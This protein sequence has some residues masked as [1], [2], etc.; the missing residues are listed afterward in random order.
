MKQ[1]ILFSIALFALMTISFVVQAGTP[2]A[3]GDGTGTSWNS[4]TSGTYYSGSTIALDGVTVTLGSTDDSSVTWTWHSGNAG[5]I[6]SQMPNTNGTSSTLITTF[7]ET[8]P[9]GTLPTRGCFL[10]I[11]ATADGILSVGCKPSTNS[12][13]KLVFVTMDADNPT[14]IASASVNGSIWDSSYNYELEAD[15]TYYLFQLAYSGQLSGYRFTLKSVSYERADNK[16]VKVF[17]IGDSTMANKSSATERGWGMIFPTFVDEGKVTICNYAADGRS[18]LSF[19]TEGR[20]QTVINQ[21]GDGDYVLI[22]FGHNDEKTDASLH[23]DPQTTYK[24][25]LTRFITESRAKGA[26]PVLLTPIVRRCFGSDGN[27]YDEH[28]EYAEAMRELA[29]ELSVPL[30]DMN[31]LSA[32]YENIAGIVGSRSLHEYF[33]GTEIDNTHLCQLGAY[34]TARSV[35]EQIAADERIAI[36]INSSPEALTGAY[37]STLD[38]AQHQFRSAYPSE[39]VPTTLAEIDAAVRHLRHEARQEIVN[40]KLLNG[41]SV[42]ATFALVNPDFAEGNC[43]YNTVQATRPMGWQLDKNTSGTEN[44]EVKTADGVT[45]FIVWAPTMNYIDMSQSVS[46]LPDGTYEVSALVKAS[47]GSDTGRTYLYARSGS[48]ETTANAE[49]NDTWTTIAVRCQVTDGQL[50][51]GL[52]SEGGWYAR[53]ADVHLT[54]INESS[55]P[56]QTPINIVTEATDGAFTIATPDGAAP[57]IYDAES[58]HTVVGIVAN[59]VA[60]DIAAITG[61]TPN[62]LGGFPAETPSEAIIAGTIGQS[63][64]IDALIASGKLDV[65]DI[66]GKWEVYKLQVIDNPQAGIDRALVIVGSNPRGTA[67]GLFELSR[68]MGVSPW[69]WWA[70]VTPEPRATLYAT[71]GTVTATEPS[72]RFRGFFIND[73]DWGMQPWAAKHMDT[74][75]QDIGPR[76][77]ERVFELLLRMR[78]NYMW[79]AMHECT[80]AFWYYEENPVLA[81]QY[82][83]VLGSSHAEPMLRNNVFEWFNEGGGWD[84]YNFATNAEGVT[85]YWRKRVIQSKDQEAV[86]TVGMRGIHDSGIAGYGGDATRTADGLTQIIATQRQLISEHIGDPTTVPQMFVPYKEVLSAYNT[87]RIDLPEDITL[88]WVDDNHGYIRQFPDANEQQRSGSHGIYYHLS[89]WGSP[90]DYLW[91]SSTSPSLISYELSRGYEQGIQRLWLINVGDI[92]PAEEEL[93]FCMDLAWDIDKWN[94]TEAAGYSRDWAARTFGEDVADELAAIKLEYYR[95]AAAGKPEHVCHTTYSRREMDERI[96]AYKA[97]ADRVATLKGS[98]PARLQDAYFQMVEYPVRGAYLMNVK[99]FRAAESFEYANAGMKTEALSAAAEARAAY[100]EI[101]TLTTTYNTGIASGKW[102]GMMSSKPRSQSAFNMPGVASEDDVATALSGLPAENEVVIPATAYATASPVLKAVDGLGMQTQALTTWPM[103]LTAYSSG[104]L[105]SAPSAEYDVPVGAGVNII[106]VHCLPTFPLNSSY[107]LRYAVSIDG[108]SATVQSIKTTAQTSAWDTNVLRGW[109]G[110]SHSYVSDAEKTVRVKIYF[111]DPGLVLSDIYCEQPSDSFTDQV[112]TNAD[113]EYSAE[114]VLNSGGSTVRGVPYGW[115]TNTTFPGTSYGINNDGSNRHGDNLCWFYNSGGT[116]PDFFQLSQTVS[117]LDAGTYRVQCRLWAQSGNLGTVRLFANQNVQ[118]YGKQTDYV[119]NLTDGEVNTFAGYSGTST[120]SLKD[121]QVVVTIAEGEDLTLGIRTSNQK[122]DGTRATSSSDN[123]GWFKCD[124]FRIE[125]YTAVA[126]IVNPGFGQETTGWTIDY[127]GTANVKISSGA[128]PDGSNAPLIA[129]DQNHLQIWGISATGSVSQTVVNLPNGRYEVGVTFCKSGTLTGTLFANDASVTLADNSIYKVETDVTDG[130]LS[131]GVT[132]SSTSGATL[133][134]DAFTLR[135]LAENVTI[136]E[137]ATSLSGFPA[138]AVNATLVRTLTA[139]VWQGFSLPFALTAEQI[140]ASPLADTEVV[141]LNTALSASPAENDGNTL[142]FSVAT[143]IEAGKPYFVRPAA[144][145]VNPTFEDVTITDTE[146]ESVTAGSYSFVA[147]LYNKDLPTDG[148]V[149][150]LSTAT[151]QFKRLTSGGINGLR[152]YLL[153][154]ANAEVKLYFGDATPTG[155]TQFP[156]LT[157]EGLGE[158]P[159]FDLSG[160]RVSTSTLSKG[161]YIQNGKKTIIK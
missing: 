135:R 11:V 74:D 129:A 101:Q 27:I 62:V 20:W 75:I 61:Q 93:E 148:T 151:G 29:T 71:A 157:G 117:G 2:T 131:L 68:M 146:G 127:S 37:T 97:I 70:D 94:P 36:A 15:H 102:D 149:A 110:G 134:I 138:E 84:N 147:Q 30:I 46:D 32:Q 156:S 88:T 8:S 160:R 31:V 98:I 9:F 137:S 144:D 78:G 150:Y 17:T 35:A 64:L 6:P 3:W 126:G 1:R 118:Y 121:M 143:A 69:V 103:D 123:T 154:P 54:A 18:T 14:I 24:E 145:V 90:Q 82:A 19:I 7:S 52:R 45:Y 16:K 38:Y 105:S 83:I 66:Q 51:L 140:A 104:S 80:K 56:T 34:I 81:K 152:S 139:N 33:P 58:D 114:G 112:L 43:W 141:E 57:I 26:N 42:D 136:D 159:C 155:L 96:A 10:K 107:D 161:L 115:E 63:T 5:L 122:S 116:V 76:T 130:I 72:V 124:Y 21:V 53:L 44:I 60:S 91:L 39:T 119:S 95:L 48:N 142:Y 40:S 50:T 73:E 133:D 128:K 65:N 47:K 99:H 87:G 77:Y 92:K 85:E 79:P 28:T 25:N 106:K 109:A 120:A 12:A 111:L 158:R 13:Q 59:A 67:Y 4:P 132:F 86:Y 100:D 113:F 125:P 22:Q 49:G 89:Y 41:K 23:T 55:T 153:L 108:G